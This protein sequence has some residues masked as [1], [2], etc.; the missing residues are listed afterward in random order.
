MT[1]EAYIT[2]WINSWESTRKTR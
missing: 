1:T 2:L